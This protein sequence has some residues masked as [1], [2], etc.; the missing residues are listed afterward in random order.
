[1]DVNVI[2]LVRLALSVLSDRLLTLVS[3]AMTFALACWV[4]KEPDLMRECMAGF[5]ALFVFI[6]CIYKERT[7]DEGPRSQDEHQ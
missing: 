7:K 2:K 6:P 5:F 3:L 4:M 1:M